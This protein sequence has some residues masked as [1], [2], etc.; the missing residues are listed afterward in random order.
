[1]RH[2]PIPGFCVIGSILIL[3]WICV[4]CMVESHPDINTRLDALEAENEVFT[5]PNIQKFI[6]TSSARER[7]Y[8]ED[9]KS[10]NGYIYKRIGKLESKILACSIKIVEHFTD[11]VDVGCD[12]I[13]GEIDSMRYKRNGVWRRLPDP[14]TMIAVDWGIDTVIEASW[15][16]FVDTVNVSDGVE[17]YEYNPLTNSWGRIK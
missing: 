1:M 2:T 7:L 15:N 17:N 6:G 14:D 12:S 11:T 8:M 4:H 3:A 9:M 13:F 16:R 5:D 10:W